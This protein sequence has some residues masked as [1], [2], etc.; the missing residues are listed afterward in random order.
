MAKVVVVTG[1]SAGVGR[2][3]VRE[4]ARRGWDV[5][6]VARGEEGLRAAAAEVEAAGR[7]AAWA[8]ADVGDAEAVEAAA[9]QLEAQLGPIDAW[10]NNAMATIFAPVH[11]VEPAEFERTVRTCLLGFV[12]GTQA[13]LRRMRPRD[14]G[15][16]VQV[17]SSLAYRG[18]P[19]QSAYCA[20]KFGIRGFTE[21]LRAE[22]VHEGSGV[23]VTEVHLPGLDTPQF[24][25]VRTRLPKLPRPVPPVFAPEVAAQAIAHAVEHPRRRAMWVGGFNVA[26]IV[27]S[28]LAP[29]V[30]DRYLG[31]TNVDAQQAEEDAS[32]ERRSTDYLFAPLPGDRGAHG[33]FG[34]EAKPRSYQAIATRHRAAVAAGLATVAA[35]LG[36]AVRRG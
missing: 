10:V 17:G 14:R 16:I 7:R 12:H 5:G 29:W 24:D 35:G 3:T 22:L 2:A 8:T 25:W 4:L 23:R 9:A 34:D 11:E 15:T 27:G 33:R 32:P 6:L 31:R 19:L 26:V 20:S 21:S 18:I 28:R 1:A 36:A 13:A 30:A